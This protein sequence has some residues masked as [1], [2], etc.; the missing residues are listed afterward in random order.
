MS[1]PGSSR[2]VPRPLQL[3]SNSSSPRSSPVIGKSPLSAPLRYNNTSDGNESPVTSPRIEPRRQ[4]SLLYTSTSPNTQS[5]KQ[6]VR[7]NTVGDNDSLS[8][9]SPI[10]KANSLRLR[11]LLQ[12]V[13]EVEPVTLAEKCVFV[14]AA[15]RFFHAEFELTFL[16]QDTQIYYG[17][18]LRKSLNASNFVLSWRSTRRN[19]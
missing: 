3:P 18:L 14:V 4:T 17:S 9:H 6:H 11:S 2:P 12:S 15:Y 10:T 7:R 16:S 19:F 1:M 5:P 13:N 8:R